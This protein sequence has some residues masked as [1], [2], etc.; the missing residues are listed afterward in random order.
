MSVL[1]KNTIEHSS[2]QRN[3]PHTGEYESRKG[4][5]KKNPKEQKSFDFIEPIPIYPILKDEGEE[6]FRCQREDKEHE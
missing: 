5:T 2:K 3:I 1:I 6:D 4:Y